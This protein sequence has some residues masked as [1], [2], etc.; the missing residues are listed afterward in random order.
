MTRMITPAHLNSNGNLFGGQLMKWMDETSFI[1]AR[2]F[3]GQKMVTSS[4]D[5]IRFKKPVPEGS[6]VEINAHVKENSGVKL[7]IHTEVFV[8]IPEEKI[9]SVAAES[10]F[11]FV[12]TD[13]QNHPRRIEIIHTPTSTSKKTV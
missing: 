2:R 6:I 4:V 8:E 11:S 1:A 3:T 12:H 13:D 9:R 5:K 10:W 7:R